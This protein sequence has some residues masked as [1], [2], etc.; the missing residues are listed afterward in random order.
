MDTQRFSTN[1]PYESA[2]GYSRAV[3]RGPFIFVSG[4][5]ALSPST[6]LLQPEHAGDARAQAGAAFAE[7]LRAVT[8]LGGARTDVVRVRMFVAH[9]ENAD[10]VGGA[11]REALGDVAPAATMIVGARFVREEMPVELEI[12]AV[13]DVVG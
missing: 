12:D 9:A 4:T 11:L 6:G 3:R 1:N 2:F 5:T 7:A 13:V 10:R 8:A